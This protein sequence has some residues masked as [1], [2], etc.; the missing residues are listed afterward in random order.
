M[1]MS[2]ALSGLLQVR[3]D[4]SAEMTT[5]EREFKRLRTELATL[6]AAIRIVQPG[7]RRADLPSKRPRQVNQ[8]YQSGEVGRGVLEALRQA[9]GPLTGSELSDAIMAAHGLG[10][11]DRQATLLTGKCVDSYLRRQHGRLLERV[12]EGRP[13]RWRVAGD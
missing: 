11:G 9:D 8:I 2:H 5:A 1:T 7:F 12:G 3:A 6:D 13:F 10:T 4:K